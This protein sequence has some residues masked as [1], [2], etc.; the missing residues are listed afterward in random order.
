MKQRIEQ[1]GVVYIAK[2]V[3]KC[4]CTSTII[5]MDDS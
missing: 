1:Y 4:Q 3:Q 2:R 5:T